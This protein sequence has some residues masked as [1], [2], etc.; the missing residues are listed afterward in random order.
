MQDQVSK[1]TNLGIPAIYLGSAQLDKSL[2]TRALMSD[3]EYA[4]IFVTPEWMTKSANRIQLKALAEAGKLSLFAIDEAHLLHEWNDFR[5]AF[6]DLRKLKSDFPSIPIMA[7]TATASLIVEEDIKSLLHDPVV[8]KSSVNRPNITLAAEEIL[9]DK[10]SSYFNMFAK[11]VV[12]IIG[13]SICIVYTDFIA[14]IGPILSCLAEVGVEAVGYHGEMDPTSR[15]ES[16]IKWTS[17]NVRVIVATK[18]FGLG[19][20]KPNIRHVI[21]N[22][23][24]ESMLSWAQELGRAG[25]DGYSATAT[26]LYQQSNLSHAN[27]WVLNNLSR[28]DRCNHILS[29]FSKSWQYVQAHTAG[30]CRRKLLLETF[31]ENDSECV[32]TGVCCDVCEQKS[33]LNYSDF[34]E[35]LKIVNDALEQVGNKGELKVAEWIRGSKISWTNT[36]NKNCLSYGNHRGR[37][38]SF[39]RKFL[40]QCHVMS[41]VRYELKSIIKKNGFYAV[42]GIYHVSHKGIEFVKSNEPLLLPNIQGEGLKRQNTASNWTDDQSSKHKRIRN[43]KGSNILSVVKKCLSEP[44]NWLNVN[45][46]ASYQFPG[47]FST[48]VMQQLYFTNDFSKLVQSCDDPHFIWKDIQLS[49]GS[50]NKDRLITVEMQD[51]KEDLYFRSSPCSGVKMCPNPGCSYIAPIRDKRNCPQHDKMLV[52]TSCCPVDFVYLYPK[53]QDDKRRWFGGLVRKQ[54]ECTQPQSA[55]SLKDCSVY[56]TEYICSNYKE[57]HS[58]TH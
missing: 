6:N 28:R 37:D 23:V 51:K 31:S 50:L 29:E 46:K 43:G 52:K 57:P 5:S 17:E 34:K 22:G 35:E 24:P 53:D 1:L 32:A 4:L 36:F 40:R 38:I 3:S 56:E 16:Y 11:R 20:N 8:V 54:K 27:A 10:T 7:L 47:V 12:E 42:Y 19:I 30:I 48:P 55:W 21:R 15:H 33:S 18:A 26:I 49:K 9:V 25:R 13:S 44:E 2:E 41:L 45:S 39:W 14:D 58:Y